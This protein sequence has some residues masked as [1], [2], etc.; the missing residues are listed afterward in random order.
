M[1]TKELFALA[2]NQEFDKIKI[3]SE[4]GGDINV[5]NENQGIV[6][7]R[8]TSVGKIS[9]GMIK[10]EYKGKFGFYN[11]EGKRVISFICIEATDFKNGYA[12]VTSSTGSKFKAYKDGKL[13]K[14][15][16]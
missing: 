15:E 14:I 8:F 5:V 6:P 4:T 3:Y 1:N 10:V 7:I 12:V 13:E 11:V 9:E 2:E 16:D